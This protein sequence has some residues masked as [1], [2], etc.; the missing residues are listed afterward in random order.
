MAHGEHAESTQ[1][2]RGVEHNR[3]E[4]TWHLGVE[5]NL[6]TCLDLVL[7]LHQQVQEFLCVHH[8]LPEVGHKAN[9]SCVPLVHNLK[10][11]GEK[12]QMSHW[13]RGRHDRLIQLVILSLVLK[14]DFNL[15]SSG[16]YI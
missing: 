2:L 12:L 7:T 4:P 10:M 16:K 9:E 13:Y 6:D 14:K 5:A 1:L 8:S 3:G 15:R 11:V